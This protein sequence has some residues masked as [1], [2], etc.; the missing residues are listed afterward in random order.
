MNCSL[1]SACESSFKSVKHS[2]LKN[3]QSNVIKKTKVE[4]VV[5]KS[6]LFAE[7]M[8]AL[9]YITSFHSEVTWQYNLSKDCNEMLQG[10]GSV[11]C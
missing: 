2:F 11:H 3:L 7:L 8:R 9:I 4:S 6:L 10:N 5:N 1:Y